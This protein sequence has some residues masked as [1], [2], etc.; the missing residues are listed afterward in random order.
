MSCAVYDR[1]PVALRTLA[2]Q[3][4]QAAR[5]ASSGAVV[6]CLRDMAE[7]YERK[8]ERADAVHAPAPQPQAG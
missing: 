4:R 3:C 7:G 5:A 1:D 2:R 6:A 8:A